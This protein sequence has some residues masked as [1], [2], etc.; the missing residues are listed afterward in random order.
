M[1]VCCGGGGLLSG[2]ATAVKSLKPD[3]R[4]IGVEPKG[5]PGLYL[6][7]QQ[8][9][10]ASGFDLD[11]IAAGLAPPFAG[12]LTHAHVTK[13][14]DDLILVTDEEIR[15]GMQCCFG[16]G[17]VVEPSGAAGVGAML[18]GKLGSLKVCDK[19]G[20]RGVCM[21]VSSCVPVSV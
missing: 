8:G 13:Y 11:T 1:V 12:D 21:L 6:S 14:V 17:L 9:S 18:A 19:W 4:V 16:M 2:V 3:I 5:A 10:P 20:A 7:R 15:K